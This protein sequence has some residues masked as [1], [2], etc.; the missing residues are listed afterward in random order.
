MKHRLFLV[1]L[2]VLLVGGFA[3]PTV[4]GQDKVYTIRIGN[5]TA[6]DNPL[7][8]AFEKMAA[9]MNEKS[10]GRIQAK[11]LPEQPAR[12]SS[13]HDRGGPDGNP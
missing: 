5:V 4:Y 8:V 6:P 9:E 2:L 7:N 10:K 3:A 11:V 13:I 1:A 12:Q